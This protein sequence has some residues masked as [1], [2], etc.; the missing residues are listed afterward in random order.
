MAKQSKKSS[1]PMTLQQFFKQH[2]L[3]VNTD[4][5]KNVRRALR[6]KFRETHDH[7]TRWSFVVGDPIHT[8]LC[9]KYGVGKNAKSQS[10]EAP[11]QS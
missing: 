9:A 8:F 6:K 1:E 7:N 3:D 5:Q 4:G 11:A 2:D 10:K